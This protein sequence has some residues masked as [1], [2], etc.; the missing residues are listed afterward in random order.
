MTIGKR[1]LCVVK[2]EY[3]DVNAAGLVA[4]SFCMNCAL[5]R[6]FC[7]RTRPD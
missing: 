4:G 1:F 3:M 5:F 7:S 6:L 2:R